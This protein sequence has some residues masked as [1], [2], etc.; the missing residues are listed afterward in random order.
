MEP[1]KTQSNLRGTHQSLPNLFGIHHGYYELLNIIYIFNFLTY[2]I[3]ILTFNKIIQVE[4]YVKLDSR[5]L[6]MSDNF[7]K[8]LTNKPC[9]IHFRTKYFENN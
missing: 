7:L 3:D 9:T 8:M 2:N 5:V 1:T 6:L 4:V